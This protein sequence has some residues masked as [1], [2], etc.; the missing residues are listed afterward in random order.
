[1]PFDKIRLELFEELEHFVF[2]NQLPLAVQTHIT[3]GKWVWNADYWTMEVCKCLRLGEK[4]YLKRPPP[5]W[6][7]GNPLWENRHGIPRKYHIVEVSRFKQG[8]LFALQKVG[9]L[10]NNLFIT[11]IGWGLSVIVA[12]QIKTWERISGYDQSP[13]YDEVRI[14]AAHW[15]IW[16]QWNGKV[17]F[18]AKK[19]ADFKATDI[20][21]DTIMVGHATNFTKEQLDGIKA[22]PK[23]KI[24]IHDGKIVK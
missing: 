16:K 11:Q 1:M 20:D 2:H 15:A 8:E 14:D 24:Y 13:K 23:I 6:L 7:D 9:H 18:K 3:Q 12:S 10:A 4:E 5:E 17:Y 22:E 21:R 19:T